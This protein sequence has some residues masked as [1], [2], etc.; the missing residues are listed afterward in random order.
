MPQVEVKAIEVL[1]LDEHPQCPKDQTALAVVFALHPA[2]Y[3]SLHSH[4][5]SQRGDL[6]LRLGYGSDD[7]AKEVEELRR[8]LKAA[9]DEVARYRAAYDKNPEQSVGRFNLLELS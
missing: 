2:Q 3:N 4:V 7:Q 9:Q 1:Q 8:Q 5:C 6:L